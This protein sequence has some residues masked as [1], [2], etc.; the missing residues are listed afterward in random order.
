MKAFSR[1]NTAG[2]L[3]TLLLLAC[4]S[5]ARATVVL[6]ETVFGDFEVLL[7]EDSTPQTVANFLAYVEAGDYTNTFIHRA[8]P[9]FIV[10]GGGY[11]Y[12]YDVEKLMAIDLLPPVI[13]EPV[14]SNSRGTIAMAKLPG[15]PNSAQAQWFINLVDN[16]FLDDVD[17]GFT[18]FG[19]VL[20]NG[21][22][23]VDEIMSVSRFTHTVDGFSFKDW[24]LRNYTRANRNAGVPVGEDQLVLIHAISVLHG[25]DEEEPVEDGEPAEQPVTEPDD[26]TPSNDETTEEPAPDP[27][28]ESSGDDLAEEPT[29]APEEEGQENEAVEPVEDSNEADETPEDTTTGQQPPPV[30]SPPTSE[31]AGSGGGALNLWLLL[32]IALGA[33]RNR[34]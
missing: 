4:T 14:H 25:V 23:V 34:K 18:V 19:E 10:Q 6:F 32:L 5:Q 9:D 13:N 29:P 7:Y 1:P 17:E 22:D 8:M 33:A 31:P 11:S 2:V 15:Q 27:E 28:E 16:T 24:P 3:L 26:E 12:D 30:I 20:D 21:M